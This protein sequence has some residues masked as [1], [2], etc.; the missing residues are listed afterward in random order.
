MV[1]DGTGDAVEFSGAKM[2]AGAPSAYTM[3]AVFTCPSGNCFVTGT[4]SVTNGG[5]HLY[6]VSGAV[7]AFIAGVFDLIIGVTLTAGQ[8]YFV[9]LTVAP[10]TGANN[11]IAHAVNLT[12]G[13]YT[14]AGNTNASS[15][16]AGDGLHYVGGGRNWSTLM[17]NGPISFAYHADGFIA[18]KDWVLQG[19]Q[20]P[21]QLFAPQPTPLFFPVTATVQYA[22]PASDVSAGAWTPSTGVNLYATLDE[23]AAD[24]ADYD[25]T[26]SASTFT[27]ALGSLTDPAVSTGHILSYRIQVTAGTLYVRILQGATTIATRTHSTSD[28]SAL[29]TFDYTLTGAEADSITDYTDLRVQ[30]ESA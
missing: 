13:A 14:S 27:V 2:A 5:V 4:S 7:H 8:T 19:A 25:S 30:F 24:D 11:Y 26:T 6:L 12:T 20:N 17:F 21:W 16:Q 10:F 22:R 18:S 1:F 23:S 15:W 9:A 3:A 28:A 29:T